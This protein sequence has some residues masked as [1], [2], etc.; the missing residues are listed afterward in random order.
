M[1]IQERQNSYRSLTLL[2]AQ[3][4]LYS[5]SK[6]IRNIA[7][8][9]VVTVAGLGVVASFVSSQCF[10]RFLP[11][12]VIL[13]WLFDQQ[14]LKKRE[15]TLRTEA[16]TLQEAFDCSVLDLPWPRYKGIQPPT[17]DRV[18]QLA[19][20]AQPQNREFLR[21]W[22]PPDEIPANPALAKLHCQRT[23]CWWDVNLRRRYIG[24]VRTLFWGFAIVL[25]LLS[26]STGL[27]VSK[28]VAMLASNV[29][30]IAWGLS[31]SDTH[32]AAAERIAGIHYLLSRFPDDQPPSSDDSRRIQN[33]IFEHRSSTPPIPD[34]F[35]WWHRESQE[36]EAGAATWHRD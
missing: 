29:R 32:A 26:V 16:A 21:D 34:W 15:Q 5:R 22:Y 8:A 14:F 12:F 28:L 19:A 25:I 17:E 33:A 31:E 6:K 11:L 1:S 24:F 2:A 20:V 3:R 30:L 23:N 18:K 9:I 7:T 13:S 35:Y 36:Q 4:V 10:E 27:T